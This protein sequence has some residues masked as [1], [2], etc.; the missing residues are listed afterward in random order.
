LT[1][2]G[3]L[4][5]RDLPT[6]SRVLAIGAHSDDIELNCGAALAKWSAAGAHVEL[7]VLTDGSKG[8]WDPGADLDELVA[9]RRREQ[10]EAGDVLGAAAVHFL[11]FPDGE[12]NSDLST[13]GA[14]CEVIRRSRPSVVLGHDP[15]KRYRLH[16]DH[17][18]AGRVTVDAI[19][20][21]R[22]PHF[23]PGRGDP[24]RP[25]QLLLFEADVVDH[26]EDAGEHLPTK[27]EALFRHETQWRSTF[28]IDPERPDLEAFADRIRDEAAAAGSLGGLALAEPFKLVAPL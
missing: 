19:V 7:G 2:G 27:I 11:G 13:R 12:L 16:P 4:V 28:G 9:R 1:G 17:F 21:A 14:V 24:H 3:A 5:T 10:E 26:L 8:T 15:W 25:D 23:F 6:P 22:D 18:H 20:A